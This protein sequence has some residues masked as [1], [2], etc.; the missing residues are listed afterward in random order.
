MVSMRAWSVFFTALKR[1]IVR[2]SEDREAA[3]ALAI[4]K[5]RLFFECFVWH[6][7]W[8][9]LDHTGSCRINLFLLLALCDLINAVW[10][11][12]SLQ[13]LIRPKHTTT[14]HLRMYT[15][16]CCVSLVEY[17]FLSV[18]FVFRLGMHTIM[19][20]PE[21]ARTDPFTIFLVL[22]L[23]GWIFFLM[24][25]IF[26]LRCMKEDPTCTEKGKVIDV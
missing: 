18:G 15:I 19:K 8:Q 20:C 22:W 24:E 10:L 11:I 6:Y 25:I 7:I 12:G 4:G 14:S 2:Y 17:I 16:M 9:W 21:W 1:I 3:V 23:F 26:Y 5:V 13:V